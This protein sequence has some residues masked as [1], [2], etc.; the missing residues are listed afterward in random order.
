MSI[1]PIGAGLPLVTANGLDTR[2]PQTRAALSF[3]RQL[4]TQL[5]KQLAE[6][7]KPSDEDESAA[8]GT[9][10]DML[11]GTLADAVISAGGLG[12]AKQL[13]GDQAR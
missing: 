4:V 8:T 2:D 12:L 7:A 9:Y 3:E 11:P 1:A 5:T 10:R 13:L 6:T